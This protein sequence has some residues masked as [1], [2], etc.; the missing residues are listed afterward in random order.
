MMCVYLH[1]RSHHL[2]NSAQVFKNQDINIHEQLDLARHWGPLHKHATTPVP[3]EPGLDEVHGLSCPSTCAKKKRQRYVPQWSIMT[4]RAG[5]T[6]LLFP[7]L[8]SGTQ[9]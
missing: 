2:T 1:M 3:K 4:H 5:L 6:P 9:T 7:H 8:S